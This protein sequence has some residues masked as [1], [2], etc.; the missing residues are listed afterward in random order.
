MSLQYNDNDNDIFV[1]AYEAGLLI[2][3]L[4]SQNQKLAEH[5]SR[6]VTSQAPDA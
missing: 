4:R 6:S 3:E 1:A 2:F 5:L